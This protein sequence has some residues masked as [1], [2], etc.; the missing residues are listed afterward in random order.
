MTHL[1]S[2]KISDHSGRNLNGFGLTLQHRDLEY[3]I[4]E[5][6]CIRFVSFLGVIPEFAVSICLEQSTFWRIAKLIGVLFS[7]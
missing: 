2:N 7:P 5:M 3:D 4:V 1:I 6:N